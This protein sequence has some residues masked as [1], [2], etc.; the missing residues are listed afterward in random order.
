MQLQHVPEGGIVCDEDGNGDSMYI[1]VAGACTVRAQPPPA[2]PQPAR[3]HYCGSVIHSTT[4]ARPQPQL[5]EVKSEDKVC[6]LLS[7]QN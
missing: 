3:S 4:T 5:I 6:V 1:V 2:K 7:R